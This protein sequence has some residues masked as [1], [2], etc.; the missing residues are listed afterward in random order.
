MQVKQLH[1]LLSERDSDYGTII[2]PHMY[3]GKMS[4]HDLTESEYKLA[5]KLHPTFAWLLQVHLKEFFMLVR[6]KPR[7]EGS[8]F[9]ALSASLRFKYQG[10]YLPTAMWSS[11]LEWLLTEKAFNT[12]VYFSHENDLGH[13]EEPR[14][15]AIGRLFYE[16]ILKKQAWELWADLDYGVGNV[17]YQVALAAFQAMI[18]EMQMTG[19]FSFYNAF[20]RD[21]DKSYDCS[22]DLWPQLRSFFEAILIAGFVSDPQRSEFANTQV[23]VFDFH[24]RRLEFVAASSNYNN[25]KEDAKVVRAQKGSYLSIVEIDKWWAL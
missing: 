18:R 17:G 4:K 13:G 14:T 1:A 15:H 10:D 24:G 21:D 8:L 22:D 6:F 16:L 25:V 7:V 19:R 2:H 20:T 3:S 9:T 5:E 12:V 11:T 23:T